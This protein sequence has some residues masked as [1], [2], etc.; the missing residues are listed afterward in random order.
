MAILSMMERCVFAEMQGVDKIGLA[1]GL[2]F[3]DLTFAGNE[4]QFGSET[5]ATLTGIQTTA[6]TEVD[7]VLV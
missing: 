4:I 6:L 1:N 5:L 7:F 3:A 2:T